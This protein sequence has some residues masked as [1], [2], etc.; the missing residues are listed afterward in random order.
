MRS[1]D[2]VQT[3]ANKLNANLKKLDKDKEW[4]YQIYQYAKNSWAIGFY[5]VKGYDTS[6]TTKEGE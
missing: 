6:G 4:V 2:K 5:K 1:K 3:E